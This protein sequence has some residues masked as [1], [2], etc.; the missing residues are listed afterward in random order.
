MGEDPR[1]SSVQVFVSFARV[2]DVVLADR[3]PQVGRGHVFDAMGSGHYPLVREQGSAT[4]VTVLTAFE[5]TQGNLKMRQLRT[6]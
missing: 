1:N 4:L 6:F 2:Q 3:D 5:L